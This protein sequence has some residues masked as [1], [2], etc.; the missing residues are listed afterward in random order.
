MIFPFSLCEF[1]LKVSAFLGESDRDTTVPDVNFFQTMKYRH[2]YINSLRYTDAGIGTGIGISHKV[3][4]LEARSTTQ[5][6]W[7]NT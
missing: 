5:R 2:I 4:M 7:N 3:K 1:L 6:L